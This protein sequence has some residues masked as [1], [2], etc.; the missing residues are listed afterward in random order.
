MTNKR[1]YENALAIVEAYE[2]ERNRSLIPDLT[3][4]CCKTKKLKPTTCM[5]LDAGLISPLEM[6]TGSWTGGT[7]ELVHF[8]Y[9]STNDLSSFFVA[10]C[11]DCINDLKENQLI[12]NYKE[13]RKKLK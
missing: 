3:C 10:I 13:L 5:S 2:K 4:I 6:H 12:I 7:V 9:G 8:G 1:E 11:D